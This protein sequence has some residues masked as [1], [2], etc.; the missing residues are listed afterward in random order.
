M[1]LMDTEFQVIVGIQLTVFWTRSIILDNDLRILY[2]N[3]VINEW[4][5]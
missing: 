3:V 2:Y 4:R 5:G 1:R